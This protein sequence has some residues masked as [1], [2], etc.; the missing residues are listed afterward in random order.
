MGQ[1][2]SEQTEKLRKPLI[3]GELMERGCK[4]VF[5]PPAAPHMS[6]VWERLVKT[7]KR[8]IKAI[9]A[10]E[11]VNEEVLHTVF[12]EVERIS[13][14]RPLTRNPPNP[15]SFPER[16]P[17]HQ[18][19]IWDDRRIGQIQQEKMETSTVVSQPLL[20]DVVKGIY[21][22]VAREAKMAA[23]KEKHTDWWFGAGSWRKL[24]KEQVA[25]RQGY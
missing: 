7:V 19:T 22:L 1:I 14:G 16:S 11:P 18:P 20:E 21:T 13:N 15:E 6:G 25:A 3:A 10:Q 12:T 9:M 24:Y 4:W 5:H 8:S 23:T 17:N 2:L